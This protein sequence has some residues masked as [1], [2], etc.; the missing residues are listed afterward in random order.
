[1]RGSSNFVEAP[2]E[3]SANIIQEAFLNTAG[4]QPSNVAAALAYADG[5]TREHAVT[6]L[7]RERGNAFVQRVVA[8]A[9]GA[10]GRMVGWS[11]PEMV[12]EVARRKGAGSPLGQPA[13]GALEGFFGADLGHVRVHT[14]RPAVQ[15]SR[16]L[17]ARAFT[18][19][20][21]IFFSPGA[22]RPASRE[23]QSLLA[24][25]LTHVAQQTGLTPAA[26]QRAAVQRDEATE[27]PT[28][29][30]PAALN[31]DNEEEIATPR[32]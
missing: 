17:D 5:G 26:T 1:M 31:I 3:N 2:G 16:E 28:T 8:A 24:H 23:G 29:N 6:Q 20:R 27:E 25:E 19:G 30:T 7:Q 32:A 4:P 10:S 18:V 21:D 15:L 14:D 22:Y 13:R 11:R 12:A 9:I